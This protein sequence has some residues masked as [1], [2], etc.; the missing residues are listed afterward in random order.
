MSK[1]SFAVV[2]HN[3]EQQCGLVLRYPSMN[4]ILP[5]GVIYPSLGTTDLNLWFKLKENK[6]NK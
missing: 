6:L 1:I 4:R 2:A 3:T 5:P